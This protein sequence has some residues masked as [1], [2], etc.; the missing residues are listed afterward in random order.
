M[1]TEQVLQILKA[2]N[3]YIAHD[4]WTDEGG[5]AY[6]LDTSK[7]T[8][9]DWRAKGKGPPSMR[10]SRTVYEI[11]ALVAWLNAGGNSGDGKVDSENMQI[12]AG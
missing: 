6:L 5:A 7:R 2:G 4:A 8:L 12:H 1:T 9:V 10:T 11:E 3:C